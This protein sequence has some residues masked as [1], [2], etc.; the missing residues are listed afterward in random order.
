MSN[1]HWDGEEEGPTSE[2]CSKGLVMG[3]KSSQSI[4]Q[5]VFSMLYFGINASVLDF[6]AATNG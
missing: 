1:W 6:V 2:T 5:M 4:Q 3:E